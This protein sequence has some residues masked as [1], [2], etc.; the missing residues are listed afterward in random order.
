MDENGLEMPLQWSAFVVKQC[1]FTIA[2]ILLSSKY[3]IM[4]SNKYEV[5]RAV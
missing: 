3:K 2:V 4:C 1:N 5:V